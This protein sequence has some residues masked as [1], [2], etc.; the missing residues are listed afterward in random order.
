MT[1]TRSWVRVGLMVFGTFGLAACL[2]EATSSMGS[3]QAGRMP[4]GRSTDSFDLKCA[5]VPAG[6]AAPRRLTKREYS[7]SVR[8]LLFLDT[9]FDAGKDLAPDAYSLSSYTNES[10]LLQ[11]PPERAQAYMNAAVV[12]S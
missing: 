8:D 9:S 5:A 2:G 12:A 11:M 10:S 1:G 6:R 3:D 4:D 7:N